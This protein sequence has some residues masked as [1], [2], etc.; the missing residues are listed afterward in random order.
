MRWFYR[1]AFAS[2]CRLPAD[3]LFGRL[4]TMGV[5]FCYLDIVFSEKYA[6]GN[7]DSEWTERNPP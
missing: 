6:G 4:I 3:E 1:L 5:G 7:P 2:L